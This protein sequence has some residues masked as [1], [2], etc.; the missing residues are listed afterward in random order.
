MVLAELQQL[1]AGLGL[2]GTG[3]M[4]KGELV[5]AIKAAQSG[6]SAP[7]A[8]DTLPV[9]SAAPAAPAATDEA[10]APA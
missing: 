3:R 7:A 10:A 2:K 6:G 8:A 5:E 9:E 4:R 1:A